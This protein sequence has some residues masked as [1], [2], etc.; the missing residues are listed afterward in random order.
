MKEE[1]KE[2]LGAD[3]A[4]EDYSTGAEISTD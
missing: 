3:V 1:S 4:P 2:N